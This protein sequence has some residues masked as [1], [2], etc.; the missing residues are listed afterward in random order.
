MSNLQKK[1]NPLFHFQICAEKVSLLQSCNTIVG[2]R[3]DFI[4]WKFSHV[5]PPKPKMDAAGLELSIA[6]TS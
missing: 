6:R 5:P 4:L 2:A 1:Q 3:S